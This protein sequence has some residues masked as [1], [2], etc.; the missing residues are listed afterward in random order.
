MNI[1]NILSMYEGSDEMVD[2]DSFI[3]NSLPNWEFGAD[4]TG[5]IMDRDNV[6]AF[7]RR[8]LDVAPVD[9][10]TGDGGIGCDENPEEQERM[11]GRLVMYEVIAGIGVLKPHGCMIIKMFTTFTA[12]SLACIAFMASLFRRCYM[13]KPATSKSSNSEIYVVCCDFLGLPS[14]QWFGSL[15]DSISLSDLD[16]RS[17]ISSQLISPEW[18]ALYET[19]SS[20][21]A[22]LTIFN[23]HRILAFVEPRGPDAPPLLQEVDL[24][25][26][27]S[28][29]SAIFGRRHSIANLPARLWI[30]QKPT[31]APAAPSSSTAG[32]KRMRTG[33]NMDERRDTNKLRETIIAG[34]VSSLEHSN[35]VAGAA[36]QVAIDPK[37]A[38]MLG[39][40]AGAKVVPESAAADKQQSA[41]AMD[42]DCISQKNA[43]TDSQATPSDPSDRAA[44]APSPPPQPG[45]GFEAPSSVLSA[46]LGAQRSFGDRSGI[47]AFSGSSE[48]VRLH[49]AAS[50]LE[51]KPVFGAPFAR[52]VH[53]KFCSKKHPAVV[54]SLTLILTLA[55]SRLQLEGRRGSKVKAGGERTLVHCGKIAQVLN[56]GRVATQMLPVCRAGSFTVLNG[57]VAPRLIP[58]SV[59]NGVGLPSLVP[60]PPPPPPQPSA[61]TAAHS[62]TSHLCWR[63]LAS[64]SLSTPL[65]ST[66]ANSRAAAAC[67]QRSRSSLRPSARNRGSLSQNAVPPPTRSS[68]WT[69]A[70]SAC[71]ANALNAPS[72]ALILS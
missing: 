14:E 4:N 49:C 2:N 38:R 17:L 55:H 28:Q 26:T 56:S 47:G 65:A 8:V 35:P 45:P 61:G 37:F 72:S 13:L 39:G 12:S 57:L 9:I 36:A 46:I 58:C 50:D 31:F 25:R 11:T 67:A 66:T 6:R 34:D 16:S 60:D 24:A 53:T 30:A 42:S 71:P 44:P 68:C 70:A 5:N 41:N 21:F 32:Q 62:A 43:G 51:I 54:S 10:F 7:R 19:A 69:R 1:C 48:P 20:A 64:P 52:I 3:I 23:L 63:R 59:E 33:G 27:K 15:L 18:R 40:K 29:W 22:D